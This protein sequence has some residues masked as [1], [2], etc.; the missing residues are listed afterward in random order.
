MGFQK[1]NA[2]KYND[3]IE[4]FASSLADEAEVWSDLELLPLIRSNNIQERKLAALQDA[5]HC[6]GVLD[7]SC[8][9]TELQ[10]QAF[11][12]EV[13]EWRKSIPPEIKSKRML[14]LL[15]KGRLLNIWFFQ[16]TCF[17][18]SAFSS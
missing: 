1:S 18:Q 2:L 17:S 7:W 6:G 16:H 8:Y 12:D 13:E 15:V 11:Q 10:V 5:Q 9:E 4:D 14:P 3:I